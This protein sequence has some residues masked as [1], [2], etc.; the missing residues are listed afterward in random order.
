MIKNFLDSIP[1]YILGP[2]AVI[3]G[4]IYFYVQNPPVTQCDSQFAVFK[5]ETQKYLYGSSKNG[6]QVPALFIK[7]VETC[8]NS[9][10]VGG[11][12]DWSEGLKKMIHASRTIPDACKPRLKELEPLVSYYVGSIRLY[13]QISWNSTEIVRQKL[14]HWL[15]NEDI[16]VFCRLKA[17]YS[18]LMSP[19]TYK[20]L[21]SSLLT[22]LSKLKSMS[23]E[24]VWKRTILSHNCSE[25]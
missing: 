19:Q 9:N 15:D 7:D 25:I 5:K 18:R 24:E 13:S 4:I 11:C 1:K 6:I 3:L 21:E 10:S 8:R 2:L 17:E 14:F 16:I 22:E 23:R 12:Y 20:A